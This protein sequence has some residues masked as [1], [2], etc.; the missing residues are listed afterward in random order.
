MGNSVKA[1]STRV[2]IGCLLMCMPTFGSYQTLAVYLVPMSEHFGVGI[3]QMVLMFSFFGLGGIIAS[4][5]LGK[6][7][8]TFPIKGI[9]TFA[10]LCV[11]LCFACVAFA[12]NLWITYIG[13]FLLSFAVIFAGFAMSHVL[14][15][16]WFIDGRGKALGALPIGT[17]LFGILMIPTIAGLIE[18]YGYQNVALG[19]GIIAGALTIIIG[20]F[21]LL[22]H[23]TKYGLKPL[24]YTKSN[25]KNSDMEST[26]SLKQILTSSAF[27]LIIM[28]TLSIDI[29]KV[30]FVDNAS[31]F[32]QSM[33]MS[34]IKAA[35]AISI[36]QAASMV[37]APLFGVLVDKFGPNLAIS[38]LSIIAAVTF[39]G[40]S[41]LTGWTGAVIIA[42]FS[43]STC[44]NSLVGTV[45]FPKVFGTKEAG[46]LVGFSH[47]SANL[48][49]VIGAPLAGF[50]FDAT[51]SYTT[52]MVI[53]G[54]L[55]IITAI[56]IA[57]A[58]RQKSLDAI[59]LKELEFSKGNSREPLSV[60]S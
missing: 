34:A 49:A 56:L 57:L 22:E 4:L 13:A 25:K 5:L 45:T 59:K 28:A 2:A 24:G 9:V 48:G 33:G 3:G 30:G 35:F 60:D 52:F 42:I 43:A 37:W 6:V 29:A 40:S 51:G 54:F 19:Q 31:P 55:M 17:G 23:P 38:T 1:K 20:L 26:M 12:P 47:A 7:T 14:I 36:W 21:V 11:F 18:N 39:F 53:A 58:T 27:W 44:I 15:T 41:M 8:K 16:W 10:G 32:Y 46:S 50:T